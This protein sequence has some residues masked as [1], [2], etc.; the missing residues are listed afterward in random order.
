M[1]VMMMVMTVTN[2]AISTNSAT[3]AT[4]TVLTKNMIG[5]L[6][7]IACIRAF[8]YSYS[9]RRSYSLLQM[10]HIAISMVNFDY[11]DQC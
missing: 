11:Q 6:T 1:M 10:I 9:R 8:L 4:L 3:V 7:D 2:I 5:G